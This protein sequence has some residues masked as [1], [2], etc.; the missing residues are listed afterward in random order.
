M[1]DEQEPD[2]FPTCC[3]ICGKA[4]LIDED[5]RYLLRIEVF[6]AY[7]PLELTKEDLQKATRE[8]IGR[9]IE[10]MRDM[11]P[12]EL[13]DSVYKK[14]AFQLCPVCQRRYIK[15]P[16]RLQESEETTE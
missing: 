9:L 16:L 6:A 5:V 1:S 12:E 15:D 2:V 8:E 11:S 14:F 10:K 7:D 3:D 4:L 13:E